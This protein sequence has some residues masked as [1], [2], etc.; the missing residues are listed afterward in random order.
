MVDS[1]CQSFWY[2]KTLESFLPEE[3]GSES[4]D[5]VESKIILSWQNNW[6]DGMAVK[7]NIGITHWWMKHETEHTLVAYL[8][9]PSGSVKVPPKW[10]GSWSGSIDS[11]KMGCH[12]RGSLLIIWIFFSVYSFMKFFTTAK[13]MANTFGAENNKIYVLNWGKYRTNF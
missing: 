7:K 6:T 9:F 10:A 1:C 12:F 13:A 2:S 3:P 11:S 5:S 8:G 4:I